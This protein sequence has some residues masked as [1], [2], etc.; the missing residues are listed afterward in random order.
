MTSL[1]NPPETESS[2]VEALV[3]QIEQL[4]HIVRLLK[5][6]KSHQ[7]SEFVLQREAAFKRELHA[8]D[9]QIESLEGAFSHLRQ[10]GKEELLFLHQQIDHLK[11]DLQAARQQVET[12]GAL[13]HACKETLVRKKEEVS[14]LQLRLGEMEARLHILAKDKTDL[15]DQSERARQQVLAVREEVKAKDEQLAEWR[16]THHRQQQSLSSV[17]VQLNE[18]QKQHCL[19]Q[20]ALTDSCRDRERLV[21]IKAQ[22]EADIQRLHQEK[23]DLEARQR[24][25]LEERSQHALELQQ[26]AEK[27]LHEQRLRQEREAQLDAMLT[28]I[29]TL[30]TEV[31]H[32]NETAALAEAR[33]KEWQAQL[34]QQEDQRTQL[35]KDLQLTLQQRQKALDEQA[36]L[37]RQCDALQ[38]DLQASQQHLAK[39]MKESAR[40]HE[41]LEESGVRRRELE[42]LLED[43]KRHAVE[44]E[45]DIEKGRKREKEAEDRHQA[46]LAEAQASGAHWQDEYRKAHAKAVQLEEAQRRL[47]ELESKYQK[48]SEILA[49]LGQLFDTAPKKSVEP[50]PKPPE[51][52]KVSVA[53]SEKD[54]FSGQQAPKRTKQNLF[55]L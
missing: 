52:Q 25:A 33:A 50:L 35:E 37:Q 44:L 15:L 34:Q 26:Q 47:Q 18:A 3:A 6:Q 51:P 48:V 40:L 24:R 17:E 4:K 39:K 54:L 46:K 45:T 20:N 16:T 41:S 38:G 14:D 11:A 28:R 10:E 2:E 23:A 12:E 31:E 32:A 9:K 1:L 53:T 43:A 36:N 5:Q 19:L 21:T 29:Q 49:N 8:K 55:D 7:D 42:K 13:L 30:Q 27:I 22:L